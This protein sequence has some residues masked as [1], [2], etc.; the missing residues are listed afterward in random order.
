MDPPS[1][2]AGAASYDQLTVIREVQSLL[3]GAGGSGGTVLF[4]RQDPDFEP[5]ENSRVELGAGYASNGEARDAHIDVA[6]GGKKGYRRGIIASKSADPY[7]DGDGNEVRSGYDENSALVD[8]AWRPDADSKV[9]LSIEAV[10]GEDIFYAGAGMGAPIIDLD[11]I[12]LGY[13]TQNSV[14]NFSGIETELYGSAADHVMDNYSL[15]TSTMM[16]AR[17]SSESDTVR[18]KIKGDL[19]PGDGMLTL[20]LDMM[21]NDRDATCYTASAGQYRR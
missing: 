5:D 7:E 14:G 4:E 20:G 13:E 9:S 10:R 12:Q 6:S 18:G 17:V 11:L 3:Y 16:W 1:A 8:L 19:V 2:Y 15:R 21:Q